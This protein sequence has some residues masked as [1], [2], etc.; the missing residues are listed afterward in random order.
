VA[1]HRI[2]S[3]ALTG[4]DYD[5]RRRVLTVRFESGGTYEYFGVEEALYRELLAA[6]PHPWSEV[7]DRVKAHRY[8]RIG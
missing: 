8:R 5:P 3:G 2:S 6:Q 4:V 1:L 7:S